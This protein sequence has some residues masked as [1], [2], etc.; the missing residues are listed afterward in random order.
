MRPELN[1]VGN[2]ETNWINAMEY[3]ATIS[4][5]FVNGEG[6]LIPSEDGLNISTLF[7]M[8]EL[9]YA[10]MLSI[11]IED[12][13]VLIKSYDCE[14]LF[15]R[16]GNWCE[17]FYNAIL[18]AYNKKVLK[19]LFISGTPSI[20]ASGDYSYTEDNLRNS[21]KAEVLLYDNCISLL[22]PD[23]NARR[24]P[25]CFLT[26]LD[27]KDFEITFFIGAQNYSISRI[28]YDTEP[29]TNTVYEKIRVQREK[30][31]AA[32]RELDP[33][34]TDLQLST[35][36][37]LM[38][39]G[40]AAKFSELNEIAPTFISALEK[41]I[42][43]SRI[44][45]TYK[46]FCDICD[47]SQIYVGFK[48][49]IKAES[50][51]NTEDV[52]GSHMLWLIVPSSDAKSCAVEFAGD[53]DDS[54]A[55]FIYKFEGDFDTFVRKLNYALESIDFKREVIRLSDEE[56]RKPGNAD[57]LMALQR[58]KSLQ[59]VRSCFVG[60]VIHSSIESWKKSILDYFA[61]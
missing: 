56:L 41:E 48:K 29:F 39:E 43:S 24:I 51:E 47:K 46:V 53:S 9:S 30:T 50:T 33:N 10:N 32:L 1:S 7:D 26:G 57:Y 38:P 54:A 44:S 13:V 58:N 27:K 42:E 61:N 8:I 52:A 18:E 31:I 15:S 6:T 34:L 45:E 20:T 55:T 36:S 49:D 11:A 16:M 3:K 28:G 14:Y 4:S 60:R 37:K 22:T 5:S 59:L 12:Y 35:I 17:P 25:L 21:G 23:T 40:A 2:V 19:S